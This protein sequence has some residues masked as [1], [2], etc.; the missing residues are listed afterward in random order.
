MRLIRLK[1]KDPDRIFTT[2]AGKIYEKVKEKQPAKK[3]SSNSTT[4]NAFNPAQSNN[5]TK[6]SS[7]SNSNQINTF[8]YSQNQ[9]HGYAQPY[10]P[11]YA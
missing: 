2:A 8:N 11:P 9:N 3:S 4:E 7:S 1:K 6:S 5:S 10:V